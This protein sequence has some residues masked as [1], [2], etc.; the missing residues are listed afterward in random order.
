MPKRKLRLAQAEKIA[1]WLARELA[2]A[3]ERIEIAGSIRRHEPLVGDIEIVAIS[4]TSPGLFGQA[5]EFNI[6]ACCQRLVEQGILE[7]PSKNGQRYKQ[8][9]VAKTEPATQLDL[10]IVRPETWGVLL[11]LRTGPAGFSKRLVTQRRYGGLLPDPLQVRDGRVWDTR[12]G[13]ALDTPEERHFLRLCGGWV[14]PER[15]EK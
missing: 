15:R 7:P 8:F 4:S 1:Q 5:L 3:C 14:E 2:P 10:F 11:A 9:V 6:V 13:L 12:S